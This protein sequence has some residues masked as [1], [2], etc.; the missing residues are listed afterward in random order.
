[1]NLALFV[2][3]F[4]VC[5]V[6]SRKRKEKAERKRGCVC[7]RIVWWDTTHGWFIAACT[8]EMYIMYINI[9]IV[10]VMVKENE[11]PLDS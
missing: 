5:N 1:M 11:N 10:M 8:K 3:Y 6:A 2:K 9:H 4:S 7:A